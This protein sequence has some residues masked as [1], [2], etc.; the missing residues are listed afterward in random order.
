MNEFSSGD[1]PEDDL[2]PLF[3]SDKNGNTYAYHPK[4]APPQ[5]CS[6]GC[7]HS[8]NP[9]DM[10][11]D[12]EAN[13]AADGG[14]NMAL[15]P[16]CVEEL[17]HQKAPSDFSGPAH[18]VV[19]GEPRYPRSC[20]HSLRSPQG[21]SEE[22]SPP[23]AWE[24]QEGDWSCADCPDALQLN[25]TFDMS[26][27]NAACT[28]AK[29]HAV[30]KSQ[31]LHASGSLQP[32]GRRSGNTSLSCSVRP[33][34]QSD[35]TH[36][37]G[38]SY[39]RGVFKSPAATASEAQGTTYTAF[40]EVL[41]QTE[42]FVPDAGNACPYS[43]GNVTSEYTDGP[44]QRLV[45]EKE[46][47]ALTPV[48][49]G[50][51]VPS[52][53]AVKEFFCLSNDEPQSETHS[54]SSYGPKEMGQNLGETVSGCLIDDEC[55]CL[56]PAFDNSTAPVL[57]PEPKVTGAEHTQIAPHEEDL[58]IQNHT[59]ELVPGSP[60]GHSL[61]LTWDE[62][63]MVIS[64]NDTICMSTPI[65]KPLNA[66]F[67]VSP[68]EATE[69]C[70]NLEKSHRELSKPNLGKPT[71]K[72][73][74]PIGSKVRKNKIISYPRP[75][76][77]NVK[78]KVMSRPALQSHDPALSK[79]TPRPQLTSASSSPSSVSS[80][81]QLTV[82][83]KTRRS[84]LNADTKTETPIN[85]TQ[86]Q[87]LNKLITSQAERVATHSKNASHKVARTTPALKSNREDVD[88]ASSSNSACEPGSV[89]SFLQKCRGLFS[90]TMESPECL[91]MTYV[92]N[93][94][95]ISPEEKGKQ[96]NGALLEKQDL[97]KDIL[98]E[99]F[100]YGSLFS[101]SA[102]KTATP[103][104]RNTPKPDASSLRITPGPK[105][106]VGPS[107]SCLRC[108]SNSRT[109]SA[110]RTLSYQRIRR[111]A[112]SGKPTSLKTAQPSWVNLPR[113]LPKSN[114][115]LKSSALRRTGSP[116]S[117]TSTHSDLNAYSSN[118][119]NGRQK[120]P[121]SLCIQTQTPPDVLSSE[122]TLELAQYKT[123]SEKQ[124]RFI[125][126]LKQLV[127]CGNAKFE[128][129]TVVIQ[130]LLSEREEALQQHKALSQE[131]LSLR[132][133]LVTASTA[134]EKLE[135]A[136]N[137]LQAAYEGFVQKLNQQ[138][139]T[140][141]TELE[142]R[143]KEFYTEECEKLQNIYIEEAEKYKTQLQE[144]FDNL[145]AAHETSKLE[146][147]A[148]HSD[149]VEL[150]KKAY[151]TSLSEIKKSHEL[152][153]KSLE[154]LL[155]EKQESL[156]KQITDLKSENEALNEKLKSEEQ[157]RLS[158]EKANL[159]NPQIMYLEQE[160]ESLKAVLEIKNEKLHQQ[161]VKL[162]KMEKLED[163]NTALV[164]KLKRCQQ[165]NEELK[166][167][168]DKHIAISRQLSN[169]QATL[170][171]WLEKESKVNKRLSMENEEL[172][173]KLHNGDLCGSDRSPTSPA[174]PFQSPRNS[175]SFPSPSVSPR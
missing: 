23:F 162:M 109:L 124:S 36:V 137:E 146:I 56:V 27:D 39:D 48:S 115:S 73:N 167:R 21:Q 50:M 142:N 41:M 25:Q 164:D 60:P 134:C 173:W 34:S 100:E 14:E 117:I 104:G 61:E 69:K 47:H 31:S 92:S 119:E 114:A 90:V 168:I 91:E 85:K 156:E 150:L 67:F 7:W 106:K 111:A 83:S 38:T 147:E 143:L 17:D 43:S 165:E 63:D 152:E 10:V 65:P 98:N 70:S 130:H 68:V 155:S 79:V 16:Q 84:D 99:T 132:G 45:G 163:N 112:G 158:R 57:C 169:E 8:A 4:P 71:T 139:Q 28:F 110:D 140:D 171:E 141:L 59:I 78:A 133:E 13:A 87:Q 6:A 125:L 159:K 82:L 145:S 18:A 40:P 62:N 149:E 1:K 93:I 123:K 101:G 97:K 75:N 12:Y 72:A 54:A 22:T 95:R 107:A 81:R 35:K 105:A 128:A 3:V 126:H 113:P 129:L 116:S 58:E 26:V 51:D 153:K 55:P 118:F 174:I 64:A 120:T 5:S 157:K 172:L 166:A 175:G 2:Q 37:T 74:T 30:G 122:K 29:H 19:T 121:R 96:E 66:T 148:S 151:E 136:R 135:K 161:D 86:K 144:Q 76:F 103:A 11:M 127:S 88:K 9:D 154:D 46:I 89:A 53:S 138:H 24:P 80:S 44:Q 42:A 49:D 15:N 77:K 131:L 94:Q 170:Q 52:G 102:S 32:A 160:L 33:S 108:T 20:C